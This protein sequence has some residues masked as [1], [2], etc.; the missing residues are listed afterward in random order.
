MYGFSIA[1][2]VMEEFKNKQ[3][4]YPNVKKK[5]FVVMFSFDI[6]LFF[7]SSELS[8]QLRTI[9]RHICCTVLILVYLYSNPL[10]SFHLS[11]SSHLIHKSIHLIGYLQWNKNKTINQLLFAPFDHL[12]V[13]FFLT[14][15]LIYSF[16]S[17]KWILSHSFL[18]L[19][20]PEF[21]GFC[22]CCGFS[23]NCL[24][25]CGWERGGHRELDH[26]I[27]ALMHLYSKRFVQFMNF[28]SEQTWM[29]Q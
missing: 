17:W 18:L 11:H 27:L 12:C 13:S 10:V 19:E 24:F 26:C 28:M 15:L 4:G 14:V 1:T 7:V 5:E 6:R 20:V 2:F 25:Y 3:N 22:W 9:D 23:V 29:T 21:I 8:N 16:C